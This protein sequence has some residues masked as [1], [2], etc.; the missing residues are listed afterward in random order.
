M[1]SMIAMK[2]RFAIM[3]ASLCCF[4]TVRADEQLFGF[5]RGAET[6]PAKHWEAYQFV[7]L[8]EGK[9]EGTYYGFHFETEAEYGFTDQLQASLSVIQHY[10]NNSGVDGDRD[11]LDDTDS[12]RFGGI[13]ASAKYRLFSP[14]KDPIGLALRL[15]GGYLW[16]DDV[17][18]LDQSEWYIKPEIDLQK[19][20]LEDR[21]ICNLD[22]G[23]EWAWG[24]Q[25]AEEYPKEISFEGA[26]GVAYRFAPNWYAGAEV[27][28]R[29]EYPLFDLYFFE[30]RVVYA[31]PSIHYSQK[32]WWAT[33]T[34]NYQVYGKGVGEPKDGQ[35]FAE[36][37]SQVFRL[38]VGFNF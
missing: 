19:D 25:P 32:N 12:Y 13:E 9:S 2:I 16:H 21:L 6:L 1:L 3:F 35:T 26:G 34:W 7:T 5:V 24:K 8:N 31:G 18:G 28:T 33:L 37:S 23:V 29:W 20:F 27:R 30:H 22:F 36:E 10:F 11:A 4:S 14:F 15:E 17:D 38:K